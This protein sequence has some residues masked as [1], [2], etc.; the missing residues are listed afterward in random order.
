MGEPERMRVTDLAPSSRLKACWSSRWLL[1]GCSYVAVVPG[2][3]RHDNDATDCR[4]DDE[5]EL[6][7][8]DRHCGAQADT[9]FV[10]ER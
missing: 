8:T 1:A 7:G 2:I 5:R 6:N 10:T 4:M 9:P 3:T